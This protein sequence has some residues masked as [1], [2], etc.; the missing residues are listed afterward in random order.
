MKH[1]PAE[2]VLGEKSV[3]YREKGPNSFKCREEERWLP[4]SQGH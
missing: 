1:A 3:E 2:E 4:G